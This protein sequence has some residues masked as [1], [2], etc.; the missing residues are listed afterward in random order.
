MKKLIYEKA[1]L[2]L[3]EIMQMPSFIRGDMDFYGSAAFDKLYD[4]FAFKTNE[5][6]YGTATGDTGEP[7]I[8]ILEYLEGLA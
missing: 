6:P 5:M 2:T 1:G 4:Y 3:A 8:W 7:D